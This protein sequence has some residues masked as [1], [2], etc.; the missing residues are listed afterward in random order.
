M[1]E[2]YPTLGSFI[3]FKN[4]VEDELGHL[5]RA[6]ELGKSSLE[7]TAWLRV[8]DRPAVPKR[9]LIAASENAGTIASLLSASNVA[10]GSRV[11]AEDG[12]PALAWDYRPGQPLSG[13]LAKARTEGFP[14]P[15][16]NALLI[17]EKVALGLT[18][19]LA[20]EVGGR[21]LVHGFL[22]PGMVTVTN[23]GEAVV[24]GFGLG[25]ALLGVLDD[26]ASRRAC[27][28]YLAPEVVVS[29]V[30]GKRSDVY[31]LGAI[32]L[33]L[34]TGQTLPAAPEERASALA[35]AVMAFDEGPIPRDIMALLLR[36]LAQQ[37]EDRFSSAADFKKEL[38]K[39]LF[40]GSYSP[41]T[42]NL[43]LF[44]DRL[45]RAEIEAEEEERA[46]E[47]ALDV[48]PYL[49]PEPEPVVMPEPETA[50]PSRGG[51][52]GLWIGLAAVVLAAVVAG[53]FLMQR[54]AAPPLPAP[55]PTPTAEQL[56]AQKA[57]QQQQVAAL[58]EQ[59]VAQMMAQREDQIRKELLSRQAEI[60]KLQ[61]RLK[62]V[63]RGTTSKAEAL[64]RRQELRRQLAEKKKA[65][66]EQQAALERERQK[67]QQEAEKKIQPAAAPTAAPTVAVTQAT[68]QVRP[69]APEQDAAAASQPAA[70]PP[71]STAAPSPTPG[72]REGQFM[73]PTQVDTRPQLLRMEPVVWS[74]QALRSRRRGVIIMSATV[75]ARG[76]VT[77]VKV[78]RADDRGFGIPQS[79]MA[80][81]RKYI[82]KPAT[83]AHVKVTSTATITVPYSF[84]GVVQ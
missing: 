62:Q 20:V 80:A 83:K 30:P 43:A 12:I 9:E 49:R 73:D 52:R 81:A 6:G 33:E 84:R 57:A 75:N 4:V 74:P 70:A 31:S 39:L 71:T 17:M 48:Q 24:A 19:A 68:A 11:F 60:S 41:T 53:F 14:V 50:S 32:L 36:S 47:Q 82:F 29:R 1:P 65:Q 3:L 77:Q 55:T 42:F 23:D 35:A 7:R 76:M 63:E 78:L 28:P 21:S 79:A 10:G 67:A 15:V 66:A 69:S 46:H 40:G 54:R 58:V 22:T 72:I 38:D 56:A 45:F 16:D 8:F 44:M 64:R 13:V 51:G 37:P 5:Y 34:L 61:K 27:A 18:A 26:D 25:D 59:Q 2:K